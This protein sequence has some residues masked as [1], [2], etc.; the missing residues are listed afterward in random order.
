MHFLSPLI[1]SRYP[2][3]KAFLE[4]LLYSCLPSSWLSYFPLEQPRICISHF[5]LFGLSK[6]LCNAGTGR[7]ENLYWFYLLVF[8]S[9]FIFSH[10]NAEGELFSK[11]KA[12][13]KNFHWYVLGDG[14]SNVTILS[15]GHQKQ[16]SDDKWKRNDV[17]VTQGKGRYLG[18]KKEKRFIM[19]KRHHRDCCSSVLDDLLTDKRTLTI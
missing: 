13:L 14:Q 5:I 11:T 8:D 4:H 15:V 17:K 18:K 9:S 12:I 19:A 7:K 2:G 16:V 6:A 3:S 1:C 10:R